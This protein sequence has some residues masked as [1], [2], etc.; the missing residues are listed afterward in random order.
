VTAASLTAYLDC[1]TGV[2]GD[3]FL[4]ALLD[5]GSTDGAFTAAHLQSL[6]SELAPEARVVTQRVKSHGI[7]AIGVSVE[8]TD[9]P[10]HRHWR[11]IRTMLTGAHLPEPV[12]TGAIGVFQA[13]AE[14]EAEAHGCA[15]DDVHFH[16]VGALDSILDVVGVCAGLHALR[17]ERLLA[18]AVAT[19]WGTVRTSHGTLPVPAPAAA[20][21]L[22]GLPI[23]PGPARADGSSPGELTTPTGAALLRILASGFGPCPP[24]TPRIV[25]YGAGTRDIGTPNICRITCGDA[26]PIAVAL[27]S[28][29]IALLETNADHLSP[30]ALAVAA[31]QLL[32]EG[33]LDVWTTPIVMKK[34]RSAV[35]LNV[36]VAGP[37]SS[38]PHPAE[39]FAQRVVALTGSLGVRRTDLTRLAAAR[40]VIEIETPYGRVRVKVAPHGVAGRLRPEAADIARIARDNGM[41]YSEAERELVDLATEQIVG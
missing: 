1:S 41:P 38:F 27:S 12:R 4:G 23:V 25:G 3:K 39:H 40:E 20:A 37:G 10:V 19:G 7:S 22:R 26:N 30:E 21:L 29:P 36:L 32:A 6:L 14:A 18:G 35:T 15:P 8:A 28:E 17:V 13:L 33:A 34:G 31:E 9:Q 5:A 16:E 2:S 11:D 24:M